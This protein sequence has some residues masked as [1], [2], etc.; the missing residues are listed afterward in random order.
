MIEHA[1]GNYG[2]YKDRREA[3]FFAVDAAR[4]LSATGKPTRV[5]AIDHAG[6]LLSTWTCDMDR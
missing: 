4:K 2:P 3:T 1:G 6:H 5:K